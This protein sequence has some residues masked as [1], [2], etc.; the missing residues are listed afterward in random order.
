MGYITMRFE[1][2][3]KLYM[4]NNCLRWVESLEAKFNF[5]KVR[6][7]F[8]IWQNLLFIVSC[9]FVCLCGFLSPFE[10]DSLWKVLKSYLEIVKGL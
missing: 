1:A 2:I 7:Q 10:F 4:L 6:T 3:S 8:F 9:R 5:S